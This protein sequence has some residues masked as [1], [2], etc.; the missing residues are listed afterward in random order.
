MTYEKGK[1]VVL[2]MDRMFRIGIER[3]DILRMTLNDESI[4]AASKLMKKYI[5]KDEEEVQKQKQT[6]EAQRKQEELRHQRY[7]EMVRR[8]EHCT[9]YH[10]PVADL[11]QHVQPE[12]VDCIITDPPYPREFLPVYSDLAQFAE[13]ALKPGGSLVVM[14]GQSYIQD[15]MQ[16]LASTGLTYQWTLAYLT[17]GGQATQLWQKNVNTFWKPIL[18]FVKGDYTGKWIGD[19]CKSAV[20]NND[21]RFHTWG[22]S[23]SGMTDIIERFTLPGQLICDP[24]LGGGT[25]AIIATQLERRFIGCDIDE[26]CVQE[27]Q[28]Q[29][30]VEIVK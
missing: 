23:E 30:K 26:S 17:P 4:H 12:S 18:W 11:S 7:L 3:G 15:V 28:E 20:N 14:T 2:Y 9:L 16:R 8:T 27:A 6:E 24:F 5:Q 22:Q 13:Y 29:V 10:C 21:K 19:V 1:E 25:T